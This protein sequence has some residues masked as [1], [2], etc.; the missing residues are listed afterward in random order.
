MKSAHWGGCSGGSGAGPGCLKYAA[1]SP[2]EIRN[3][4]FPVFPAEKI[5]LLADFGPGSG[6]VRVIFALLGCWTAGSDDVPG[7]LRYADRSRG[8]NLD[9]S[10]AQKF[11]LKFSEL[12]LLSSSVHLIESLVG[13]AGHTRRV[14]F[15]MLD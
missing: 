1:R 5:R 8:R 7:C 2:G 4:D 3:F 6:P 10:L 15:R 11:F 9:K 13:I 12:R 14:R